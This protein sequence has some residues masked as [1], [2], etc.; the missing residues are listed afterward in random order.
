MVQRKN[1]YNVCNFRRYLSLATGVRV[2]LIAIITFISMFLLW[3][4]DFNHLI[5]VVNW[6]FYCHIVAF[7]IP[8]RIKYLFVKWNFLDHISFLTRSIFF[9]RF[10]LMF[11][12]QNYNSL[13]LQI[14]YIIGVIFVGNLGIC[15]YLSK[16]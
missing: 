3:F 7:V 6:I 4:V 9:V 2:Q 5:T 16:Q 11:T 15:N 12:K 10:V 14:Y 13:K 1:K 8:I